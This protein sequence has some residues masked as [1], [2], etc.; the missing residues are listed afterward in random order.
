[1]LPVKIECKKMKA[2]T[3]GSIKKRPS[4]LNTRHIDISINMHDCV[5]KL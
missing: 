1:M 2:G 5:Y 4:Q 3:S